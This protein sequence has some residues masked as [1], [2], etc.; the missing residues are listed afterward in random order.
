MRVLELARGAED[1]RR[2]A[3]VDREGDVRRG[4]V[5][6]LGRAPE[7]RAGAL[8]LEEDLRGEEAVVGL[9]AVLLERLGGDDERR[10]ASDDGT[11]YDEQHR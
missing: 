8:H 4:A 9:L 7:A 5:E 10:R 3:A 2:R 11:V 1:A 6:G